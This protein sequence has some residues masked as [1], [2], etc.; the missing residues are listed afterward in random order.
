M[1]LHPYLQMAGVG[2]VGRVMISGE[3]KLSPFGATTR[4]PRG[5]PQ[6]KVI[7]R[8]GPRT[9]HLLHPLPT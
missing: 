3:N 8:V 1:L 5:L 2:M 4:N 6:I 7:K 9:P